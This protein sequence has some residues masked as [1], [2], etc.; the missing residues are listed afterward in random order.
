MIDLEARIQNL[1]DEIAKEHALA[2]AFDGSRIAE[3]HDNRAMRL[4]REL[5]DLE[6]QLREKAST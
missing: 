6:D 3:S 1:K 4:Y 5:Q 2:E